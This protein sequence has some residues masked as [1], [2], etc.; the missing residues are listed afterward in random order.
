M[1]NNLN[2]IVNFIILRRILSAK[3]TSL[4]ISF[5]QELHDIVCVIYFVLYILYVLIPGFRGKAEFTH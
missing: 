3:S 1:P 2:K 4:Y 5:Y